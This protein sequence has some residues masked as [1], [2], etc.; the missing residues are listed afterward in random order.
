MKVMGEF[1]LGLL[2]GAGGTLALFIYDEG[3]VFLRLSRQVKQVAQRYKQQQ[4]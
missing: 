1:I 4:V 3:E 2:V